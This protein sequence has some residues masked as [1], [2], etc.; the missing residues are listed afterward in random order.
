MTTVPQLMSIYQSVKD[1]TEAFPDHGT[2]CAC[3][4]KV[5]WEL[6]DKLGI[7]Q[8][9]HDKRNAQ[10]LDF[11]KYINSVEGKA[12]RRINYVLRSAISKL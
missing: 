12:H 5:I 1:H 9:V 8:M 10:V 11:D 4:D 2:N 3:M 6:C 7:T